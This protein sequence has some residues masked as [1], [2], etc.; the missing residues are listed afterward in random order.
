MA[1]SRIALR[2]L[3]RRRALSAPAQAG[4]LDDIKRA[5]CGGG[6]GQHG[7][8]RWRKGGCPEPRQ[9]LGQPSRTAS[10]E[11]RGCGRQCLQLGGDDRL[12]MRVESLQMLQYENVFAAGKIARNQ[13]SQRGSG[14]DAGMC[15]F[16]AGAQ[17]RQAR[18]RFRHHQGL[19]WSTRRTV[20]STGVSLPA[21]SFYGDQ[22]AQIGAV[23]NLL[24]RGAGLG[25]VDLLALRL[26]S[27]IEEHQHP[28][29]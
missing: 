19:P 2:R 23:E 27:K 3:Q 22:L 14:F 13:P 17:P 28:G 16:C 8:R 20:G 9:V 5:E 7:K 10:V 29:R 4:A 26:G 6:A 18:D 11:Q 1:S 12:E 24:D 15:G 25:D 21:L